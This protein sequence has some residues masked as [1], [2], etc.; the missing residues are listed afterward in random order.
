MPESIEPV[1]YAQFMTSNH[2]K[3]KLYDVNRPAAE[4]PDRIL[5]QQEQ[6]F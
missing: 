5:P 3:S 6:D 2:K 1:L 4:A